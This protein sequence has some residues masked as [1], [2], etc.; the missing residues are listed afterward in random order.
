MRVEGGKVHGVL[1]PDDKYKGSLA[2]RTEPEPEEIDF[3]IEDYNCGY[4]GG[5][6]LAIFCVEGEVIRLIAPHP[7]T[8]RPT[9][10]DN[11]PGRAVMLQRIVE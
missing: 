4:E 9:T 3:L 5:S 2:I 11:Q 7:G 6:S 8:A 10:F 1:G